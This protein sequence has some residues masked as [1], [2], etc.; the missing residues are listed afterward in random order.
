MTMKIKIYNQRNAVTMKW[1]ILSLFFLLQLNS[2]RTDD[3]IIY[4]TRTTTDSKTTVSPYQGLYVLC[5]GNMGSNK[6]SLDYLDLA[7]STATYYRNVYAERNPDAIKE[8]GDV[9]NDIKIYGSKLWM[10]IN[11]S[12]KIEVATAD[13]L[14]RRVAKIDIPNCRYIDFDGGYAYVTSY[15]GTSVID[16]NRLGAVYQIDTATCKVVKT[17]NV[18]YQPDELA[19]R[20][21]KIYVANSGGYKGNMGR[22]YDNTL[23]VIDIATMTE[24]R[25]ITVGM[26]PYR[27]RFD[28][29]G[30]LWVSYRGDYGE[31]APGLMLL[32]TDETGQM[33]VKKQMDIAVS[34][35]CIVG[36]S[37]YYIYGDTK[38]EIGERAISHGIINVRTLEIV[39]KSLSSSAE[40]AK[41]ETPYGLVVNPSTKDFY[42]MDAKDYVSSGQLLH[43]LK[44]GTFDYSVWTGDIPCEA[45]FLKK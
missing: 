27:V 17:V 16:Y 9:G 31:K 10:V 4:S 32:S 36:D 30:Q 25:Q 12:N 33:A 3:P 5:Q 15:V 28:G 8:L 38:A 43:F 35:M 39:N 29:M 14:S 23:S 45:V 6:A 13:T 18:G 22:G 1:C 24:E 37:L 19:I 41:I 21:G 34:Q 2:C 7:D 44:D 20:N 26:N 11:C 40:M 42:V